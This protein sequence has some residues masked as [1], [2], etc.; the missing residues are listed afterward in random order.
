MATFVLLIVLVIIALSVGRFSISPGEL[1]TVMWAKLSG[2]THS[3]PSTFDAVIFQIR[4]PRTI[5]AVF[6]GAALAAAGA[7]FQSLFRNPLV[8]PD[9]LGVS[10][11]AAFG[12][13][14]AVFLS[15][16][17]VAVQGLAFAGGLVAVAMVVFIGNAVR[18]HDPVLA[19]IL[20]GVVVGTLLGAGI[21]MVKYLADPYN[22]LP[23]ITFWLLGS[24]SSI[25][26]GDLMLAL[27]LV[28][29][30]LIPIYL[31][32]WR[33]NVLSLSDDEARALGI[34]VGRLR[35]TLITCATL[36]TATAVAIS[37]IIG[38]SAC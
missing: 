18:G 16:P 10:S 11:G 28:F 32:R 19:L 8:S 2:G 34:N 29:V 30:G 15:L 20:T 23:A 13:V 6:I 22:Q 26:P 31:L 37:G 4:A 3:L 1:L 5:A 7:V 25:S 33:M 38:W 24:L 35:L 17:I 9:I 14:L 21:A 12:A 27:P 36:I